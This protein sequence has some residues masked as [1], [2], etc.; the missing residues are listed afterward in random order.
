MKGIKRVIQW[1]GEHR[2]SSF[3]CRAMESKELSVFLLEQ[4]PTQAMATAIKRCHSTN[5]RFYHSP[6]I[7]QRYH[8]SGITIS[9]C[10]SWKDFLR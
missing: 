1:S 2:A 10:S 8:R 9:F 4:S 6:Q 3:A 5:P 7:R